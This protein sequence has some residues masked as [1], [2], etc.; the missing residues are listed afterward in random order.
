[1]AE[2][3]QPQTEKGQVVFFFFLAQFRVLFLLKLVHGGELN[4][5]RE[6]N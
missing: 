6:D 1:M 2:G 5:K 4:L 3:E